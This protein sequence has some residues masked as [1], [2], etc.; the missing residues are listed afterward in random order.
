[1]LKSKNPCCKQFSMLA[2]FLFLFICSPKIFAQSPEKAFSKAL[3]FADSVYSTGD[4]K[5]ARAAYL[6]AKKINPAH[7]GVNNRI[8]EID[9]ILAQSA[10]TRTQA[11]QE[12]YSAED[13]LKNNDLAKAES[14][15]GVVGKLNSHERDILQKLNELQIILNQKLELEYKYQDHIHQ[16]ENLLSTG[17]FDKATV[18]VNA[19]LQLKPDDKNATLLLNSIQNQKKQAVARF[20]PLYA[21]AR[22]A[23]NQK[24]YAQAVSVINEALKIL[25]EHNGA[26]E[27]YNTCAGILSYQQELVQLYSSIIQRADK[28]FAQGNNTEAI[29]LYRQALDV[30]PDEEYPKMQI[31]KIENQ[32]VDAKTRQEQF[33]Q[34]IASADEAYKAAQW[35]QAASLYDEAL[36]LKPNDKYA[37]SRKKEAES[38]WA[39]IMR[40]ENNYRLW[41]AQGDSLSNLE[42]W[43]QAV[44]VFTKA[45]QVKPEENY[46]KQRLTF[47]NTLLNNRKENQRQF[48]ALLVSARQ[49]MKKAAWDAARND[50]NE[51]LKLIPNDSQAL[52]ILRQI[53]Q[54]EHDEK[55]SIA[56]YLTL[57]SLGDS[58]MKEGA[59]QQAIDAYTEAL[60]IKKDDPYAKGKI[61]EAKAEIKK[62]GE[63]LAGINNAERLMKAGQ[64]EESKQAYRL[65][66]EKYPSETLPRQ[67]ILIIDSLITDKHKKEARVSQLLHSGDSLMSA[68]KPGEALEK[69]SHALELKPK[70]TQIR[71]KVDLAQQKFQ[72]MNAEEALLSSWRKEADL[73]FSNIKYDEASTLYSKILKLRPNDVEAKRKLTL[74]DSLNKVML[75]LTEKTNRLKLAADRN[76]EARKWQDALDNYQQLLALT[77]NNSEVSARIEICRREIENEI[78]LENNFKLWMREGD[79]LFAIQQIEDA[80]SR[81]QQAL[82]LKPENTEAKSKHDNVI[83]ILI[84][85]KLK[86]EQYVQLIKEGDSLEALGE[87]INARQRFELSLQIKPSE[88]YPKQKVESLG[89]I[90]KDMEAKEM[91]FEAAM[92]K[93]ETAL[94]NGQLEKALEHFASAIE[95]KP[96]NIKAR[97]KINEVNAKIAERIEQDRRYSMLIS[98]ADSVYSAGDLNEAVNIYKEALS[99]KS[100]EN[101]PAK[102]ISQIEKEIS[103]KEF[104]ENSYVRALATADSCFD[105]RLYND[106]LK[107][108]LR[109]THFKPQETYPHE[110]I[111][112]INEILTKPR[113]VEGITYE[114][115]LESALRDEAAGRWGLAFDNY[116]IAIHLEPHRQEAADG[117]KRSLAAAL[118]DTTAIIEKRSLTLNP[119][120][121]NRFELPAVARSSRAIIV[122]TLSKQP[123]EDSKI[124]VNYGKGVTTTGGIVLRILKNPVTNTFIGQLGG[125]VGWDDDNR[126]LNLIPEPGNLQVD[127]IIITGR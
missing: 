96:E 71:K 82:Q 63:Y 22:S 19:A 61:T 17:Y 87:W 69:Y 2:A 15:L 50:I 46:P 109:A 76:F 116:L 74:S 5:S 40:K 126:W 91:A 64:W 36:N 102:R 110:K 32:A 77:P 85:R 111:K 31:R 123:A 117:L 83:G 26:Q 41:I 7:P 13:A 60:T 57:R 27:L 81:Y 52:A 66:A 49:N 99:I 72:E 39:E 106:A 113:A 88:T 98:K 33:N 89:K 115:A 59:W 9:R 78:R 35:Q 122:V 55:A 45:L 30:N 108:Y 48:D 101:Y 97:A 1:M 119:G 24:D 112:I 38:R 86:E 100:S 67:K 3:H 6:F 11:L 68:N 14:A 42:K 107:A 65:L 104:M 103:D 73:L 80:A 47:I 94:S 21:A 90:I 53:E 23:Y 34:L 56:Q 79:S 29:S 18:Q 16:A 4:L 125:Q 62:Q 124:V 118:N 75:D 25:P 120:A 93:G 114:R 12:L 84:E 105:V 95:I 92:Q 20:E 8:A 121:G 10:Q 54:A 37:T 44:V 58:L 28:A 43:E 51:A 127:A 70:D